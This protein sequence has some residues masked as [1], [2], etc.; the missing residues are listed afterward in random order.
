MKF[1]KKY[2][3]ALNEAK[4]K[5]LLNEA[6]H[7]IE[8]EKTPLYKECEQIVRKASTNVFKGKCLY[9]GSYNTHKDFYDEF[10]ITKQ[11]V[12]KAQELIYEKIN[13][14][15]K[16]FLGVDGYV[17]NMYTAFNEDGEFEIDIDIKFNESGRG[18]PQF[19]FRMYNDGQENDASFSN[20][21]IGKFNKVDEFI[22]LL[23]CVKKFC[24]KMI[25]Y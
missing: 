5:T 15:V 13:K 14:L 3:K 23:D 18:L 19:R 1:D 22:E 2:F 21:S 16:P 20:N 4:N 9:V 11:D 7:G 10:A 6:L 8:I 25:K 12:V 24:E 17:S